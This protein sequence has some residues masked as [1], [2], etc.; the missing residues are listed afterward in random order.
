MQRIWRRDS[1]TQE[2]SKAETT[3]KN[4]HYQYHLNIGYCHST[5]SIDF[6]PAKHYRF[7][8]GA[9]FPFCNC[10][11]LSGVYL[12]HDGFN[13][14]YNAVCNHKTYLNLLRGL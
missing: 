11:F 3:N 4:R 8:E 13:G 2:Q 6:K 1:E 5:M 12:L 7:N 9:L 14:V 10:L